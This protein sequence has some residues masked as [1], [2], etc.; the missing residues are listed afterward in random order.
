[1]KRCQENWIIPCKRINLDVYLFLTGK[2]QLLIVTDQTPS[3][4]I[5]E[6]LNNET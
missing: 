6:Q 3:N 2:S 4:N 5:S 1:M